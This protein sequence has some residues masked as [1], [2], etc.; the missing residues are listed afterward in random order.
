MKKQRNSHGFT[1]IELMI[2][3]AIVGILAS[4]AYPSYT[5]F[6]I[7]SNRSE[8]QRELLRLANLQEQVFVDSRSY[9]ADMTGLGAGTA[10][11]ETESGNYDISVSAQSATTFTLQA[12]A[13]NIQSRD[14]ACPT[15]TINEL[16]QKNLTGNLGCWEQ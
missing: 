10:A 15:L 14:T 4:I 9:A 8:A 1:L 3:V 16:G 6:V 12:T 7:R 5:D 2:T 13:K 11:I